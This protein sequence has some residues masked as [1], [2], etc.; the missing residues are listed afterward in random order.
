MGWETEIGLVLFRD[1]D[2]MRNYSVDVA[3]PK[4]FRFVS[5]GKG[6]INLDYIH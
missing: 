5:G 2:S 3:I 6:Q 4:G 1:S